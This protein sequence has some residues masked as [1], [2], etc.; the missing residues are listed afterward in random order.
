MSGNNG[1]R[2]PNK[3]NDD[4]NIISWVVTAV[5][6][7]VNA[8]PVGL[9]FLIMKLI[10][11]DI[12]GKLFTALQEGFRNAGSTDGTKASASRANQNYTPN[13]SSRSRAARAGEQQTV[14]VHEPAAAPQP[15]APAFDESAFLE[16]VARIVDNYTA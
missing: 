6:L 11:N 4:A 5:L 1:N 7:A 2:K 10:G 12:L 3:V 9:F 15:Q 14:I 8:F 16:K 13:S